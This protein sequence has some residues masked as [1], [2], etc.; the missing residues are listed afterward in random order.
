MIVIQGNLLRGFDNYISLKTS[1]IQS[2]VKKQKVELYE[3][4]FSLSSYTSKTST[5]LEESFSTEQMNRIDVSAA[6]APKRNRPRQGGKTKSGGKNVMVREEN[7]EEEEEDSDSIDGEG[8]D[9]SLDESMGKSRQANKKKKINK[10]PNPRN[11]AW[12]AWG[13]DAFGLILL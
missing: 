11:K 8:G 9:D 3:R 6:N 13:F 5:N 12:F 7:M 4:M 2:Q 10:I 1:K